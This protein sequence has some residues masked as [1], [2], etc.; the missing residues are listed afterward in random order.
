MES[1]PVPAHPSAAWSVTHS[2]GQTRRRT[3]HFAVARQPSP[4]GILST[5]STDQQE[6]CIVR[7]RMYPRNKVVKDSMNK[8]GNTHHDSGWYCS[9]RF[10]L[11]VVMELLQEPAC[12]RLLLSYK[13]KLKHLCRTFCVINTQLSTRLFSPTYRDTRLMSS[14]RSTI[15]LTISIKP[16]KRKFVLASLAGIDR[17]SGKHVILLWPLNSIFIDSKPGFPVCA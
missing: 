11:S 13:R 12:S 8:V 3:T 15:H 6:A 17:N 7:Y 14:A 4:V 10:A 2:K 9:L 16:L 1:F 5:I